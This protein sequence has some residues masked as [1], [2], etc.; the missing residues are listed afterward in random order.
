M[1]RAIVVKQMPPLKSKGEI[2]AAFVTVVDIT[3][4]DFFKGDENAP[5][6]CKPPQDKGGKTKVKHA[7]RNIPR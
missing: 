4:I 1:S 3:A 2:A 6:P 7:P 5:K